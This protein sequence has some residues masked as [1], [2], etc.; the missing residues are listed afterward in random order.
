MVYYGKFVVDK[1][2]AALI[3]RVL[4][5]CNG[6]EVGFEGCKETCPNKDFRDQA[7]F[8]TVR[9]LNGKQMDVRIVDGCPPWTEASLL[10]ENGEDLHCTEPGEESFGQWILDYEGDVYQVQV[11]REGGDLNG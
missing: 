3:D 7:I 5:S 11:L 2:E 8:Y 4:K 9:F 1:E 10:A 6:R